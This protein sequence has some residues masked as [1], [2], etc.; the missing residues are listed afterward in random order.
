MV[1]FLVVTQCRIHFGLGQNL[2]KENIVVTC[3]GRGV[4]EVIYPK[5]FGHPKYGKILGFQIR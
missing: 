3:L 2:F 1:Y 4:L 5:R